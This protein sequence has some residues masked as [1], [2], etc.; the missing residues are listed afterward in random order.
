MTLLNA[1]NNISQSTIFQKVFLVKL[2]HLTLSHKSL[3]ET[4]PSSGGAH[5]IHCFIAW[6]G[7]LQKP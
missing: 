4:P 2:L 3:A 7:L 5:D 6:N 1:Y